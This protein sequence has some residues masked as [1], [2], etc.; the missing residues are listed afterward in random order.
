MAVI[1]KYHKEPRDITY[2]PKGPKTAKYMAVYICSMNLLC[3]FL[4]RMP[5]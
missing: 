3:L 4:P 2:K 5:A 1:S